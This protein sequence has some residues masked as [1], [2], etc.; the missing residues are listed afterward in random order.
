MFQFVWLCSSYAA[1]HKFC[2]CCNKKYLFNGKIHTFWS[3]FLWKDKDAS[4][5]RILSRSCF[6]ELGNQCTNQKLAWENIEPYANS[7]EYTNYRDKL[8]RHISAYCSG[9][10]FRTI[11]L[12]SSGKWSWQI[13]FRNYMKMFNKINEYIISWANNFDMWLIGIYKSQW[14]W[15]M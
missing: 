12:I 7:V 2:A 10:V 13:H 9:I 5:T 4:R 11:P 1:M 14:N 8:S 15:R 6:T 3:R